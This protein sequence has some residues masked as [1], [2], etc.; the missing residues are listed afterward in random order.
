[1]TRQ[2]YLHAVLKHLLE[3]AEVR[4]LRRHEQFKLVV[5][6]LL[7]QRSRRI[8]LQTVMGGFH[9]RRV[10]TAVDLKGLVGQDGDAVVVFFVLR[11]S[12]TSKSDAGEV[13]IGY[14]V[15][16]EATAISGREGTGS[17]LS[18]NRVGERKPCESPSSARRLSR[19]ESRPPPAVHLKVGY[20]AS[21]S[22]P[23]SS[24]GSSRAV[25]RSGPSNCPDR[26]RPSSGQRSF[27]R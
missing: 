6:L 12:P 22:P 1:M 5:C 2:A 27:A 18:Q 9:V 17:Y 23:T 14:A 3:Q 16:K 20:R 25:R 11:R 24:A 21:L 8:I 19:R 4:L 13:S 15:T 7:L 26:T 10:R